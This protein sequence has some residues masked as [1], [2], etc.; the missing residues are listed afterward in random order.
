MRNVRIKATSQD[1][2]F[3]YLTY[4]TVTIN[5]IND[6][7]PI[8]DEY[9]FANSPR[10]THFTLVENTTNDI[11][12]TLIGYYRAL[13]LDSGLNGKVNYKIDQSLPNYKELDALFDL[14]K[15]T[16][17]LWLRQNMGQSVDREA[18]ET[19]NM[20]IIAYDLGQPESLASTLEVNIKILDINDNFP[21]F[22][23]L[24]EK[25][26][27][28]FSIEENT[29]AFNFTLHGFDLD[30]GENATIY[31]F[32][33]ARTEND[34]NNIIKKFRIEP[35]TGEISLNSPLDYEEKSYYE[36]DVVCSDSG[37]PNRLSSSFSNLFNHQ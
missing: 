2:I 14:E 5:D 3:K 11:E 34:A 27:I 19:I 21:I 18:N 17:K 7:K 24:E 32:L 36:F 6:N 31:Y 1:G 15:E 37:E 30:F 28:E 29:M 25:R 23:N 8:F 16:G 4:L 22:K 12:P 13:D 9:L 20:R 35:L 33:R 10:F 26:E